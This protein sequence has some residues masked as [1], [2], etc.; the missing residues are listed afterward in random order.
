M[1]PLFL[2]LSYL[3]QVIAS[4][5]DVETPLLQI[6]V[7]EKI[8]T[9]IQDAK[10]AETQVTYV[11]RIE[12]KAYTLQLEKQSFLHPLFGT[13]LRDK[14]G[15]LQPY[16]SLVK[17]H[18][19]YQGHAVEIPVST[20]TLNTCSGLRGLLQLENI[21]YGIEPLESS[22]TFEHILYEIKNNKIDY[23][24]LKENY[25]NSEQ[26]SQSYRILVKP[27]KGSNWTLT[28]RIL[29]IKI[30]MDKAMFDHMGS[31]VGVATQKVVHIF[32]LINTMFSQLKVT[33]ML[34]SL[35]IWSEQ[36][37][38]ET[39][40]DADEVL[41]RFL[42]W[43]RK[44]ISQKA[45]DITYL[46][47]YKDHPDY[48]G[49]TYHGMACNPSFTA[50]I[51]LTCT[52][53]KCCNPKDCTLINEAQCGTG[54]CCD[55][56]T[57]MIAERGRLCR[58]SRDQCDFPE[59]CNGESES[60][61][62]DT[63]AADLEPCNNETAYCF[64]GV[65]RDPDR[66]CTDLFGKYAKGPNYVCAQEV[67]LQNDKFGNCH[68]RCTYSAIF[69][70]KAVCYWNFAEVIQTEKYDVQY[71]YLGGHVCV[72]AHL[73]SPTGARDDTY[74]HDGTVCGS[75]QVCLQGDCKRVHVLRG[76][77]ECEADDKC[78]GHGICN[79]LGNCQCESG[80][81]PPECDMT[82]S[83]PG[84]SMDD[85]FWLPFDKST[86]LIFKRHGLQY[87]KVLL[88][89]FYILLPFLV[90][91]AFMAVKRMIGKR[92]DKQNI[93][94]A[95]EHKEEAFSRGSVNPDVIP[96]G[97]TDQNLTTVPGSFNS[98]SYY[99]NTD[100]NLTTVPGRFYNYSYHDNTDQNLTSVPGSF[101]GYSYYGNTDQ[102]LTT[103]PGSFNGYSYQGAPYYRSIPG[104]GNDSQQP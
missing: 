33:V 70:G 12:G 36:D 59:F 2:V 57:C 4:G 13:Y 15:T 46:L 68:G 101:N 43:K 62:P 50:G 38:I 102:N 18:C 95:L 6:T 61:A 49:A 83:S 66:Q 63:K 69:C 60:C 99:G 92:L 72:S 42:L 86:P 53:K 65:C 22:A 47:L 54:P 16:F 52:H 32:G 14:L 80:F 77:R 58:K 24:P 7:P 41:Q 35:E 34:N 85:G 90:V 3:G 11:V 71:T 78:Q 1:L 29:R 73:R 81:A 94:K 98:Y 91:L 9:N 28:K 26:E 87:K 30:I 27:E 19:F 8:E 17:T 20:V 56:R 103:V 100:Q 64:G 104:D 5:K 31:E 25:A 84:G 21:T 45:T 75:G 48:V 51:A 96:G 55:K 10:E 74:V 40:G 23:S 89:S 93:S 76:T 82:P 44:E 39:N 79:N 88:I 37:K 97:N 67:N